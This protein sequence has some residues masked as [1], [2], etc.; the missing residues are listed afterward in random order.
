MRYFAEVARRAVCSR[1]GAQRDDA[2]VAVALDTR[3]LAQRHAGIKP[4][5]DVVGGR[6][7]APVHHTLRELQQ[8]HACRATQ[9]CTVV[10]DTEGASGNVLV[11][12]ASPAF[13]G[14]IRQRMHM[15]RVQGQGRAASPRGH[16]RSLCALLLL[17]AATPVAAKQASAAHS[18]WRPRIAPRLRASHIPRCSPPLP[19][20]PPRGHRGVA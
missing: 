18:A 1:K 8:E 13:P 4:P 14:W 16:S 19:R 3:P 5:F 11:M 10:A 12:L 17:A 6:K 7:L 20:R 15:P 9:G 2:P